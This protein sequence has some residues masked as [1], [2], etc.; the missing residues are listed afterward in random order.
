MYVAV[1]VTYPLSLQIL[2]RLESSQQIFEKYSNIKFH[3]NPSSGS[4][5]V[6]DGNGVANSGFSQFCER[7]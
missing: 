2:K 4:L 6:P 5:V 7:T 1:Q 3:D